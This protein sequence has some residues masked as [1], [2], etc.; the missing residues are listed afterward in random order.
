MDPVDDMDTVADLLARA[1]ERDGIA[2]DAPGR[3]TGYSFREFVTDAWKTGNLLRHYGVREDAA[4]AEDGAVPAVA[5]R[6]R[7]GLLAAAREGI[8]IPQADVLA[9]RE[10]LDFVALRP[11]HDFDANALKGEIE[12]AAANLVP[13]G[14]PQERVLNVHQ[15]L[16]RYGDELIPGI[17]ERMEVALDGDG[18]GWTGVRCG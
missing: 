10:F 17:L 18:S 13:D 16:A 2:F 1:R 3:S 14:K 11:D 5:G 8:E 6:P 15:Y 9:A 4:V 7:T 12:K